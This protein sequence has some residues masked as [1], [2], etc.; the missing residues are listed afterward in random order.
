MEIGSVGER[1]QGRRETS[2]KLLSL[3]PSGCLVFTAVQADRRFTVSSYKTVK[4]L[5]ILQLLQS[6]HLNGAGG[7]C[8]CMMAI[9]Q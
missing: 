6:S 5:L 4:K 3:G 7:Q 1:R 9:G 8:I 2:T